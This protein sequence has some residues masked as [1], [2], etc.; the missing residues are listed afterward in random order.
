M[1]VPTCDY[2]IN[3]YCPVQC[4]IGKQY[5]NVTKTYM[6]GTRYYGVQPNCLY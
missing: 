6:I 3:K 4:L 2:Y 5:N 1:K